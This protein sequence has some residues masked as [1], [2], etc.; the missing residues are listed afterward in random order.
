MAYVGTTAASSV[1]NPPVNLIRPMAH[2]SASTDNGGQGIGNTG[3]KG[4]NGLWYYQSSDPT[5]TIVGTVTYFTDGQQLGMRNGD[6]IM[7]AQ[8][9]SLGST[10]VLFGM[11][12]LGTTNS[13]NGFSVMTGSIM[14]ST[15]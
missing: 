9:S 3:A 14:Y 6:V 4:G 7:I 8:C 12:I 1:A 13:T 15:A 11:G 2:V 5:S 10:T